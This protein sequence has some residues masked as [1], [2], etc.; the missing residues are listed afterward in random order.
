MK[1]GLEK[2]QRLER[3]LLSLTTQREEA[4]HLS[5]YGD[6]QNPKALAQTASDV[7]GKFTIM[8]PNDA[9]VFA[10]CNRKVDN[11]AESYCWL[12]N[13]TATDQ[14]L[15]LTNRNTIDTSAPENFAANR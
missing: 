11:R 8:T 6:L 5:K 13:A 3:T 14:P 9:V 7:D 15:L 1:Q 12:V 10:F 4:R 2:Q